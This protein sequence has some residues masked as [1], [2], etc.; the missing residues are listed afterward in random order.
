MFS[1][2]WTWDTLSL[3]VNVLTLWRPDQDW[4][5]WLR[6]AGPGPPTSEGHVAALNV[7]QAGQDGGMADSAS[8]LC[9]AHS[10]GTLDLPSHSC[11]YQENAQYVFIFMYPN[12][13]LPPTPLFEKLTPWSWVTGLFILW[14]RGGVQGKEPAPALTPEFDPICRVL[15]RPPTLSTYPIPLSHIPQST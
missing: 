15:A 8:S 4:Q 2:T 5:S 3:D 14:L 9:P 7:G 10:P 11:V 1:I 13:I 6:G 12:Q